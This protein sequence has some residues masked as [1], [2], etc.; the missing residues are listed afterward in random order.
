[1]WRTLNTPPSRNTKAH[2]SSLMKKMNWRCCRNSLNTS[3]KSDQTSSALTTVTF[4][5]GKSYNPFFAPFFLS[6]YRRAWSFFAAA[7]VCACVFAVVL[8]ILTE[9]FE[10][11]NSKSWNVISK[12]SPHLRENSAVKWIHL[13]E[14]KNHIVLWKWQVNGGQSLQTL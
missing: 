6:L 13:N 12:E 4:L 14:Y 2:S 5:I 7:M 3:W 9:A 10:R 11:R 8:C 1:M